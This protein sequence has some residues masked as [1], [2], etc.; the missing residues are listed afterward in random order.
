VHLNS[1]KRK[2]LIMHNAVFTD[3]QFMGALESHKQQYKEESFLKMHMYV[4]FPDSNLYNSVSV[5]RFFHLFP[6]NTALL[7]ETK[8]LQSGQ[9]PHL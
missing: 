1:S 9:S 3:F 8:L 5:F 7:K 4:A 2:F 6:M